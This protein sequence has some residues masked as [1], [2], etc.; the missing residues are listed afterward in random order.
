MIELDLTL[1]EINYIL[2]VLSCQP[3]RDVANLIEKISKTGSKQI[4]EHGDEI[5]ESE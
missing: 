2:N 5:Y 3:Y 1:D 4:K